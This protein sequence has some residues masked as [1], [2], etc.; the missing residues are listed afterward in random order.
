MKDLIVDLNIHSLSLFVFLTNYLLIYYALPKLLNIIHYKQLMDHP[1]SRSSHRKST[2]SLGGVTFYFSTI[3]SL[4]FIH[5]FDQTNISFGIITG[6]TIMFFTGLK[7]DLVALSAKAKLIAQIFAVSLFLLSEELYLFT[8]FDMFNYESVALL[9]SFLF[10]LFMTIYLINAFNLI[11]GIDGLAAMTGIL[12]SVVYAVFFYI[13]GLNFYLLLALTLTG[14]LLAYLPY[15]LSAN[16]KIF[17][18]DTGSLIIGFL[19][20]I[21][22]IRFV[23]LNNSQLLL[24]RIMPANVFLVTFGIL[25][26]PVLDVLR[27]MAF[28][29]INHKGPLSADRSH[30]HHILIDKGLSHKKASLLITILSMCIFL[31]IYVSNIFFNTYFLLIVISITVLFTI[32]SLILLDKTDSAKVH[33]KKLKSHIPEQIYKKEFETRKKVI[34][35]L[36]NL[37]FKDLL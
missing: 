27:V 30:L 14:I 5:Y 4:F 9:C 13:L 6:L 26:F 34:L 8:I 23:T 35:F 10:L 16:N 25:F 3:M 22:T 19:I 17:M 36:K 11:D 29:M 28:R 21:L 24:V 32:Y 37:F 18:G 1:N 20:S 12:I 2:P 33:R 31:L 7:D 15:N